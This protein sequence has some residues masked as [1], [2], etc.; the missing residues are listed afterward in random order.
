MALRA[1]VLQGRR[2]RQVISSP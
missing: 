1:L 2:P